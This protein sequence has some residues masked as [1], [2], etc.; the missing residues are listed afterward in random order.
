M[1]PAAVYVI[2]ADD[3]RRS[4]V[5]RIPD[6]LR[7]APGVEVARND[8]HSVDDL[9]P[10][11]QQRPLEQAARADRRPQRLLAALR[12]RVLG[13]AGHV[14]RR[15]RP[16]R[17]RRGPRRRH[18]GRERRQRRDQHHHAVGRRIG[19][20]S[21]PRSARG[22]EEQAL[23][24]RCATAGS[25]ATSSGWRAFVKT[26]RSRRDRACGDRRGRERRLATCRTAVSRSRGS[27]TPTIDVNV[28]AD[29]LRRATSR[30]SRAAISRSARCP[31]RSSRRTCRCS[32][33]S[34][35]A[36]WRHALAAERELAAAVLL[37]P[38]ATGRFRAASTR[39]A[40]RT[41]SRSCTISPA[42]GRHDL[43][44]GVGAP[45]DERRHR[46]HAV[47]VVHSA[48]QNRPDAE[49][50]RQ[51]RISSSTT[52]RTSRSARSS[53]TTTTRA[54]STSRACA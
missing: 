30:Y 17:G 4:G 19:R 45:L 8:S 48:E 47:L 27:R 42:V 40:A 34:V 32:G 5:T 20:G 16:H 36:N 22:N 51:D 39:R 37:R 14:A 26:L 28:R 44:W 12:G 46:Q 31:P 15:H 6:A 25:P 1:T 52:A 35:T 49:R 50:V 9:D 24:R 2:T 7:L 18:V 54:S 21:T 23:R 13:R 10:R 38:H 11:L 33:D 41:T 3:I 29:A 53:S 43:Q